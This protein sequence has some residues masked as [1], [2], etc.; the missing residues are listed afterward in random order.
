M[1]CVSN[2]IKQRESPSSKTIIINKK[3][4]L[5]MTF[6]RRCIC[7]CLGREYV[8]KQGLEVGEKWLIP[9]ETKQ[10]KK[11][12]RKQ[13]KR[14][15]GWWWWCSKENCIPYLFEQ[16]ILINKL[17]EKNVERI[18]ENV[19]KNRK[20]Y[21]K[22]EKICAQNLVGF[23]SL[24][25]I[26][27]KN[28]FCFCF[29]PMIGWKLRMKF[30]TRRIRKNL[31]GYEKKCLESIREIKESGRFI[32]EY[33]KNTEEKKQ[34]MKQFCNKRKKD[35]KNENKK[36]L[37]ILQVFRFRSEKKTFL[38]VFDVKFFWFLSAINNQIIVKQ[39]IYEVLNE[40]Q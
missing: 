16:T 39:I 10:R 3:E 35:K 34:K 40:M 12:E 30:L 25:D 14:H 31:L 11:G 38:C 9:Q 23:L 20:K 24:P 15:K 37:K 7:V 2:T 29:E 4:S 8:R 28:G 26:R 27:T 17:L 32:E 33:N 13:V 6:D 18:H 36:K 19:E 1:K 21:P 5:L 22:T